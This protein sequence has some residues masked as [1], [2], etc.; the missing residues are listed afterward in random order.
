MK[1]FFL[2][3]CAVIFLGACATSSPSSMKKTQAPSDDVVRL[4]F[5]SPTTGQMAKSGRDALAAAQLAVE[6]INTAGGIHGKNVLLVAA[7][8]KCSLS[9]GVEA[10]KALIKEN[11]SAIIGGLCSSETIGMVQPLKGK[12]IPVVSYC[13][14]ASTLSRVGKFFFRTVPDETLVADFSARYLRGAME[15][16]TAVVVSP[17]TTYGLNLAKRFSDTYTLLGGKILH[18]DHISAES[19]DF[20]TIIQNAIAS[21]A[22]ALYFTGKAPAAQLL[23]A[24]AKKQNASF[25]LFGIDTLNTPEIFAEDYAPGIFYTILDTTRP[26]AWRARIAKKNIDDTLCVARAYDTTILLADIIKNKGNTYTDIISTLSRINEYPAVG[27]KISFD[28][29]GNITSAPFVV[30]T[31]KNGAPVRQN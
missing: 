28:T 9:G 3:V 6:E 30:L 29:N 15:K 12:N 16:E 11:V 5:V 13:A 14:S 22:Q 24:E 31:I 18:T 19:S 7:D 25:P 21:G 1:H 2:L 8:G 20:S 27:G 10:G 17:T 23:I 4:G 26:E